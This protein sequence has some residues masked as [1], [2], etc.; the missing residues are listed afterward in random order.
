M[1][2]YLII[3]AVALHFIFIGSFFACVKLAAL[4]CEFWDKDDI[5]LKDYHELEEIPSV[6][7]NINLRSIQENVLL[8]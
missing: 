2:T 4:M 1:D 6:S 3:I 8:C 7:G 5:N